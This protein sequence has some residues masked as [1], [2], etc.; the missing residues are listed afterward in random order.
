[1]TSFFMMNNASKFSRNKITA[2]AIAL[3]LILSMITAIGLLSPTAALAPTS[4]VVNTYYENSYCSVGSNVV[5][6]GQQILLVL[7]TADIPPDIG[8]TDGLVQTPEHRD[9]WYG[10]QFNVTDPDGITETITLGYSDPVGGGYYAYTPEKVGTYTVISIF[11]DTWKNSTII[12]LPNGTQTLG[13]HEAGYNANPNLAVALDQHYL[14]AVSNPVTFVC[15][16]EPVPAWTE[17]PLPNDYWTRPINN[18]ARLWSALP[19]N[20]LAGAWQQPMGQAGGTTTSFLYGVGTETSHILWTRPQYVGGYADARFGDIGYMTGHY[21][22]LEFNAII[23][24][25][26]IYYADRA[27]AYTQQASATGFNVVDLYT[28][29]LIEYENNTGLVPNIGQIYNYN[30]PNQHGAISMLWRTSGVTLPPGY[31][32][33]PQQQAVNT[34]FFFRGTPSSNWEMLDGYALPLRHICYIGNV[35]AVG[36][37]VIGN[38]GEI[39]Y[40]NT[41]NYGTTAN[42]Q[43]YLTCWNNTNVA[44]LTATP[45]G[46]GTTYWQWR[47]EGGASP[48]PA[49]GNGLVFDGSTAWSFNVSIPDIEGPRNSIL[50]QTGTIQC[51]RVGTDTAPGTGFSD[52]VG[53]YVIVAA[54]GQNNELGVVQGQVWALS[55]DRGQEG[56][57]LWTSSFTPPFVSL[58]Q[59]ETVGTFLSVG[60]IGIYPE[61]GVMIFHST[62]KLAYYGYDMKTGQELWETP[63]EPDEN[64]YSTQYNYYNGLFLTSGYGGVVIAYN[65]TTGEQAWNFTATNI[66]FES[67]YGNYP[68]NIFAICDGKIYTLA[69]EHSITNPLWR[70]PNIRCINATDGSEIW[71]LL[72]MG[73]DNGAHLTGEYMQMGDGKVVGLNYMDNEIYCIGPGP[74]ATTVSAPQT[75]PALGSSVMLTGTVTDQTPSGRFNDNYG[76]DFALKGTPAIADDSMGR[77]MEYLFENQIMPSNATGVPV[78]LTA[79]DPNGNFIHIGDVTSDIHGKYGINFTPEVSGKY[80]I[81]A[82][83]AGSKAYGP[84]SDSTYLS[85]GEAAATP[86]P[87][88]TAPVSSIA[89]TY[90]IPAI[91]GLFILVIIV[92]VVLAM[93]I[94]KQPR[95]IIEK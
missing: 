8:E 83:F 84:S 22:G 6:V 66:G 91:A 49:Y 62:K 64:Y 86:T 71:N 85:V 90:F 35:T 88:S 80:Q 65:I 81:L 38:N 40:Y 82:T 76:L 95:P 48:G 93:M 53:G 55:L 27:D 12:T 23:L 77:W 68:I 17:S 45:P 89:D 87:V 67:P 5:G 1:M 30:S 59:N 37:Q 7:W 31:T 18:A 33:A 15:Q 13:P 70:G 60:L 25:G 75:V 39:L 69:G 47:P 56:T 4:P 61:D 50:N 19:G 16:E 34:G 11:P 24:N 21:Q 92:A 54:S 79:I 28:G 42:P 78:T 52:N 44:G 14:A 73:A 26:R 72:G 10:Q 63:P 74:S 41:V 29:N 32:S 43:Y 57:Q 58:A 20:W 9:A 46:T 3:L 2:T 94:R 36:T 51:V